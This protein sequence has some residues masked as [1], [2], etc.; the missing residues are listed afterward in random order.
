MGCLCKFRGR[1]LLKS[2]PWRHVLGIYGNYTVTLDELRA[3]LKVSTLADQTNSPK[4]INNK[5]RS[6]MVSNKY[7]GGSGTLLTKLLE[8]QRKRQVRKK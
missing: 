5:Q 1:K 8:L 7:R 4:A 2:S 6:R 3:M